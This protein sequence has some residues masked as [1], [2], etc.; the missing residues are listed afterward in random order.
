MTGAS[1]PCIAVGTI[2]VLAGAFGYVLYY[3]LDEEVVAGHALVTAL[4]P[5]FVLNVALALP[6]HALV[7]A[8]V[9]EGVRDASAPEVE[10]LV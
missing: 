7:R 2:T 6:I 10:V 5:A 8:I 3:L 4:A 9:G 1:P